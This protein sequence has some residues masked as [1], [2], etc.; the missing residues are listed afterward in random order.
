[1][2][3]FIQDQSQTYPVQVLCQTL[4][5][6]RSRYSEWP[7]PVAT[8]MPTGIDAQPTKSEK[9]NT[10]QHIKDLFSLHRRRYSTRRAPTKFERYPDETRIV[11]PPDV[12]WYSAI[13][14]NP[15]LL[16]GTSSWAFYEGV[17]FTVNDPNMKLGQLVFDLTKLGVGRA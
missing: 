2:Y 12:A 14:T 7:K 10:T 5:V 13:F 17:K 9:A 16:A 1:M 11:N 8:P 6:S 15:R 4:E 3:R